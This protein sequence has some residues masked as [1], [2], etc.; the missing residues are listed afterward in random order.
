MALGT[1]VT[2]LLCALPDAGRNAV[3]AALTS[4]LTTV[5]AQIATL[6]SVVAVLE[7]SLVPAR[8]ALGL[9]TGIA[10][11]ANAVGD[12]LNFNIQG[13]GDLGVIKTGIQDY[14]TRPLL[15]EVRRAQD[16]LNRLE[17]EIAEKQAQLTEALTIQADLVEAIG[18]IDA[19]SN[20]DV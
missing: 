19:C 1:C 14:V 17:D 7:L 16:D 11:G 8:A 18:I 13:C 9:T 20:V 2:A 15:T 3:K 5:N 4:A 10:A 12:A 6:T